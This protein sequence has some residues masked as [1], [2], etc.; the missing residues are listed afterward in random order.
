MLV[1]GGNTSSFAVARS[2]R[3]ASGVEVS[4]YREHIGVVSV[5]RLAWRLPMRD[6]WR[7]PVCTDREPRS[8]LD[9]DPL[10]KKEYVHAEDATIFR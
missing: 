9:R 4:R 6:V 7:R 3:T 10:T 8:D 2:E 5:K 1:R